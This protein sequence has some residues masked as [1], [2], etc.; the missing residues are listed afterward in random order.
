MADRKDGRIRRC[1]SA[2]DE[3][4]GNEV[5]YVKKVGDDLSKT[6]AMTWTLEL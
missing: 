2:V 3:A 5:G 1:V 6:W 4:D